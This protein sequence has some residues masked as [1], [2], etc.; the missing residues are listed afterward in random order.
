MTS[1]RII[2]FLFI[3]FIMFGCMKSTN[4]LSSSASGNTTMSV[5]FSNTGTPVGFKKVS[6]TTGVDSIRIDSAI[7]VFAGIKFESDIDTVSV[8]SSASTAFINVDENNSSVNFRGPFVIH[9]HDTV[10]VSFASDTLP[11]GT[12]TGIKFWIHRLAPA[13]RF[14]DSDDFNHMPGVSSDSSTTNYCIVVWGAVHKD[15]A[16]VPFEFKDNQNIQFKV[17]GTFTIPTATSSVNI[18]LNFN[19]GSWFVNPYTGAT[20]DPTS[21]G[22]YWNIQRAIRSSFEQGRCGDWGNRWRWAFGFHN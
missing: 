9:V 1:K 10:A 16:W 14:W 11:P 3:S 7:V 8:D 21:M 15:S 20:L 19:M 17:K 12:Y 6:S 18:A 2:G 5:A 4:P 13:E 22:D